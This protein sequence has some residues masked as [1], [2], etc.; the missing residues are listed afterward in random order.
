[1]KAVKRLL[2]TF[3]SS[4]F[5]LFLFTFLSVLLT[6]P[7]S[8]AG[9]RS[10]LKIVTDL[11][12][13][14]PPPGTPWEQLDMIAN[15][16]F[17]VA[18]LILLFV[19]GSRNLK[20]LPETKFQMLLEICIGFIVN[21]FGGILG[22]HGKQYSWFVGSYFIFILFL[23][24]LGL[25]PGFQSPTADLNTT[26]AFGLIAVIG[27][28]VISIKE[29]G[30]INHIKH[31]WGD[32]WYLGFLMFPLHVIGEVARAASLALR[33][34]GNI[35]GEETV[36]IKITVLGVGLMTLLASKLGGFWLPIPVQIPILFFGMLGGFLQAFV[37]SLLTS[38]YIV[39][40]L[41]H[42]DDHH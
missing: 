10:W 34:F 42:G 37:F 1:L 23:N 26:V 21:F 27:V 19:L 7:A 15:T 24:Y 11:G 36:I 29:N 40:F 16:F 3:R 9:Y 38:V 13:P 2:Q 22:K 8:A 41:D 25:I 5:S 6:F 4:Y 18:L 39:T 35:F 30:I 31:F 17:V 12:L 20:R 32:P 33:L 14:T 28:N